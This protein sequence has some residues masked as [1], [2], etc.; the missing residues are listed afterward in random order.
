MKRCIC[1][2]VVL[3]A[4]CGERPAAGPKA[5]V[6]SGESAV[7]TVPVEPFAM[8]VPDVVLLVTGAS[9]GRLEY[10]SCCVM[11]G[12]LSGRSSLFR[13]Y[14]AAFPR[15][16]RVDI[17][18]ALWVNPLDIRNDFAMRGYSMLGYDVMVLGDQE[19]SAGPQRLAKM[20]AGSQVAYLS[21]TIR[22]AAGQPA[23]P[24]VTAVRK[25]WGGLKLAFV[26][27]A[28]KDMSY[29]PP[30][31]AE[32]I[33]FA[34][35]GYPA[36][37]AEQLKGEG[38]AVVLI[39]HAREEAAVREENAVP[40]DLVIRGHI[41]KSDGNVL[42]SGGKRLIK[43]GGGD[44]VG[45][46]ALKLSGGKI[47]AME[48]RLEALDD[49]WPVDNRFVG[50]YNAYTHADSVAALDRERGA[51]IEYVAASR[52]GECH[53]KQ[54]EFWK[55]TGHAKAYATLVKDKQQGQTNCLMCH[56][57]AMGIPGGFESI[58][59]TPQFANV[60]CQDCHRFNIEEHRRPT[61]KKTPVPRAACEACHTPQINDSL[62]IG[63]DR[64]RKE[65]S[66]PK[67]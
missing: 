52:C 2:V 7:E 37:L 25:E 28:P 46:I 20:M 11:P 33:A 27:D 35:E 65:V 41:S 42:T 38:C 44:W 12:G 8:G 63:Y 60:N 62:E 6:P 61:F 43:V 55:T 13:S 67:N 58:E 56:T 23:L 66:C 50:L 16:L 4:G 17:G 29:V 51:P 15:T 59:K 47:S 31:N 57:T 45:V 24:I 26:S 49:R 1:L 10:C 64:M 34:P 39:S 54:Y 5:G 14:E 19:W 53:P 3:L 18:D 9:N 30:E 21:T 40:A 32:K 48:Y 36:R 22:P